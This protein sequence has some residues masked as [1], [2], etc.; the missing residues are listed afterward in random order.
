V[1]TDIVWADAGTATSP[2]KHMAMQTY[3][4]MLNSSCLNNFVAY[5]RN[6]LL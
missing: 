3:R 6:M 1:P 4:S 2:N 5:P